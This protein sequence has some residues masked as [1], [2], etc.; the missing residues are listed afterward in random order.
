MIIRAIRVNDDGF[1]A[2][3]PYQFEE[4]SESAHTPPSRSTCTA[5][6]MK[7]KDPRLVLPDFGVVTRFGAK[8]IVCCDN[9]GYIDYELPE[10]LRI[11]VVEK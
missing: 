6:H 10:N 5:C 1:C 2:K 11:L 8:Y 4:S 3:C 9:A 7:E